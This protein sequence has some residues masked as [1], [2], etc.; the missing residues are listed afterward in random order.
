MTQELTY[1]AIHNPPFN[2]VFSGAGKE[3]LR[4]T[5]GGELIFADAGDAAK[6]LLQE[7]KRLRGADQID[8]TAVRFR[9]ALEAI[10]QKIIDG[11]VCDDV[12]WF[13]KFTTLHDFIAEVLHPSPP[14]VIADLFSG[15]EAAV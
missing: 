15:R 4:I 11:Q 7:W 1:S 5:H 14:P 13:D 12:A 3:V 10:Q 6:A 8:D 2:L 9:R